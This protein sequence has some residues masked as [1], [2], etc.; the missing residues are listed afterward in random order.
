MPHD[1]DDAP[2]EDE[3]IAFCA[4]R[5]ASY[6]KPTRVVVLDEMPRNASGKVLKNPLR[7]LVR[8]EAPATG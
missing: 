1:P 5:L 7:D 4:T 3:L 8:D 6:K 2:T